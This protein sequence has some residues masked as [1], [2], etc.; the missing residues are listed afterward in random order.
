MNQI[1]PSL[2]EVDA[3]IA[4][5]RAEWAALLVLRR[6]AKAADRAGGLHSESKSAKSSKVRHAK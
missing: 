4:T 3:R 1:V 2:R 6:A 5:L